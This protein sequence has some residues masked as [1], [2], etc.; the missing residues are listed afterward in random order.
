MI[1]QKSSSTNNVDISRI[2]NDIELSR[3]QVNIIFYY[4]ILRYSQCIFFQK[5]DLKKKIGLIMHKQTWQQ[6]TKVLEEKKSVVSKKQLVV[7]L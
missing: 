3:E 5:K 6:Y 7:L 4:Q 1:I 2:E